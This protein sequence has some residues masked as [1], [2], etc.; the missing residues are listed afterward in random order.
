MLCLFLREMLLFIFKISPKN[1]DDVLVINEMSKMIFSKLIAVILLLP[2]ASRNISSRRYCDDTCTEVLIN[3]SSVSEFSEELFV[4]F[5]IHIFK[6]QVR[7]EGYP[8]TQWHHKQSRKWLPKM[9]RGWRNYRRIVVEMVKEVI[10]FDASDWVYQI[11]A[12]KSL[13]NDCPN[14]SHSLFELGLLTID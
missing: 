6:N 11:I 13:K 8:L 14:A 4:F 1:A 2:W 12:I 3:N 7:Q 10:L 5:R 9:K